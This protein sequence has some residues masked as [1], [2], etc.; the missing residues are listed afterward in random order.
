[1]NYRFL[2]IF[3]LICYSCT[4]ID[5]TKKIRFDKV[6]TNSGFTL[7]YDDDYFK[8]KVV[9]KKIDNR[10][11][12]IF[13]RNLKP[14]TDIKITNLINNK[15]VI[16]K[17]GERSKYPEFYNSVI[18]KRIAK[19]INLNILE[20]YVRVTEINKNSTFVANKTKTFKEERKVAEKVPVA[21]IGIKDLSIK[22]IDNIEAKK[23]DRFIYVIKVADFY[24]EQT[25]KLMKKRIKKE[26]NLK[27]VNISKMSDTKFRVFLGP[28]NDLISLKKSFNKLL[29]LEF[30]NIE[31]LKI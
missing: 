23:D 25:A 22:P 19:E 11:L 15:S 17:V 24:Y 1:M 9:S 4:P 3:I 28:Y 30:E 7:V 31:I 21:E 26:I 20:P 27:N 14:N 2:I 5:S 8:N 13:S 12:I 29:I 18:S 16:A 10:S 6:Y